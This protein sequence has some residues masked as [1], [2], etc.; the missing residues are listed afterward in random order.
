[1]KIARIAYIMMA[2]MALCCG[3][4]END[5]AFTLTDESST[6]YEA[7]IRYIYIDDLSILKVKSD[8]VTAVYSNSPEIRLNV[9][10]DMTKIAPRFG[11]TKGAK[12]YM[13]DAD[14]K[15]IGDAD[16]VAR[17]FSNGGQK[18]MVE[19]A[20]G[21]SH[22]IYTLSFNCNETSTQYHFNYV[23]LND[24]VKKPQYY[25]FSE[26]DKNGEYLFG[27]C[28]ANG[29]FGIAKSS[30]L[31][32]DFPTY[33]CRGIENGPDTLG[34][35]LTTRLTGAFGKMMKMPLAAGNFFMGEFNIATALKNPRASTH[36]GIP[37]DKKPIQ[38]RGWMSYQPSDKFQNEKSLALY[39]DANG[40]ETT[41]AEGNVAY[42]DSCDIYAVLYRNV[43]DEGNPYYLDG[44][45]VPYSEYIVGKAS[46]SGELKAGTNGEWRYFEL[47]FDY[48]NFAMKFDKEV[49][50]ANGYSFAFVASSSAQG[51][52]FR[53][54]IGSTLKI[55]E[56]EVVC[57]K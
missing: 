41:E 9:D 32:F 15:V 52:F 21:Q 55:D 17:D 1:M 40:N 33:P 19:S 5:S 35:A 46:L 43:D 37:F 26:L 18:Y 24:P 22:K 30:S 4:D 29:G 3:C 50:A 53:G 16:K 28:T 49:L 7:D 47:D 20:N 34:V 23:E 14:N 54:A 42:P 36:F 13:V 51:G 44:D 39:L 31:P 10:A 57:E 6:P 27:W 12:I 2:A 56:I 25:T 38:L 45:N 11:L 48:D 8:S